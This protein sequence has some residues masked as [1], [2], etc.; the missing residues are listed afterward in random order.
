MDKDNTKNNDNNKKNENSI[1]ILN[2]KSRKFSENLKISNLTKKLF[3]KRNS[4]DYSMKEREKDN[5]NEKNAV[6]FNTK[7]YNLTRTRYNN[8]KEKK[9]VKKKVIFRNPNQKLQSSYLKSFIYIC[10]SNTNRS[11]KSNDYYTKN[12]TYN[13]RTE[14]TKS[15]SRNKNSINKTV[16]SKKKVKDSFKL[17]NLKGSPYQNKNKNKYSINHNPLKNLILKNTKYEKSNEISKSKNKKAK[18]VNKNTSSKSI[19]NKIIKVNCLSNKE[20]PRKRDIKFNKINIK[21][22]SNLITYKPQILW[23]IFLSYTFNF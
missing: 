23:F 14:R 6:N 17:I 16:Y 7:K 10:S 4:C 3:L 13:G 18:S 12:D 2:S 22:N 19:N 15:N 11:D 1:I 20:S 21:F 8:S 9:S 5:K